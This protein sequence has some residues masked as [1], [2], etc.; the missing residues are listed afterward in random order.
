MTHAQLLQQDLSNAVADAELLTRHQILTICTYLNQAL[1]YSGAEI[2]SLL[3]E[4]L[5]ELEAP[6]TPAAVTMGN[7]VDIRTAQRWAN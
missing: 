6:D 2:R 4:V 5:A 1:N 7:V 3:T